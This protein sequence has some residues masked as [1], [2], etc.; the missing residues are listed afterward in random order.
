MSMDETNNVA[1]A[2][3]AIDAWIG[4]D[5]SGLFPYDAVIRAYHEMG[6]HFVPDTL[7]ERLDDARSLITKQAQT[8]QALKVFLDVALD[9]YD[10]RYEYVTYLAISVLSIDAGGARGDTRWNSLEKR[11]RLFLHLICDMLRFELLMI[12]GADKALQQLP[13][14]PKVSQ[15]RCASAL[16]ALKPVI[17]RIGL[18]FSQADDDPIGMARNLCR[19]VANRTERHEQELL[20]R[21]ILPVY[22][23][24]DEYMFIRVL[25][26]F[27]LT[28][29]WIAGRLMKALECFDDSPKDAGIL[30]KQADG[31]LA[32]TTMLFS[33]LST[34]QRESFQTFRAFTEGASAIQS[35]NYKLVESLCRVPEESR[36]HSI[37]YSSVP[38]VQQKVIAGVS[39]LDDAYKTL[40]KRIGNAQRTELTQA[41]A[42]FA[43]SIKQWRSTHYGIAIKMLGENT[44][45]GYTEGTPY[46]DAVRTIPVFP[47]IDGVAHTKEIEEVS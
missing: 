23:V 26:S 13:P 28:F 36:L 4:N 37:A 30:I 1:R 19:I 34:M 17:E 29:C 8:E 35:R 12:D 18:D 9:K 40:D 6:K 41:M 21:S 11:D 42:D 25:Q 45:T 27:E 16:R 33:L 39:T 15:R 43:K 3:G 31:V 46:L 22:V 32:E 7:L 38:E 2:S 20:A 47:S 5:G 24:H 44:G 10:S 14:D